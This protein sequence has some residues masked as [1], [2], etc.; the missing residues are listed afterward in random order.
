MSSTCS[1]G[2]VTSPNYPGRYPDNLNRTET[3]KV[4]SG[5]VLRMQFTKTAVWHA[6]GCPKDYVKITDGDKIEAKT[7]TFRHI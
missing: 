2:V 4:E 1:T 6:T 3:V 5:K 7:T